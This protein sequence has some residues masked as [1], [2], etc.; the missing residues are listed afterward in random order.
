MNLRLTNGRIPIQLDGRNLIVL[1]KPPSR[2]LFDS[3]FR[4]GSP[5][6]RKDIYW[7]VLQERLA[8]KTLKEVADQL[9]LTRE[10]VRQMEAKMIRQLSDYWIP[11][12]ASEID[13]PE[14]IQPLHDNR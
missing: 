12:L 5:T 11:I 7:Q 10:R 13:L 14:T 4:K 8:G 6:M 3:L 1:V 2:D 9:G